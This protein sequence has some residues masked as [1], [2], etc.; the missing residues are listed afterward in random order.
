MGE[1]YFINRNLDNRHRLI[2]KLEKLT[3]KESKGYYKRFNMPEDKQ[4][5]D[6][7]DQEQ[8][9]PAHKGDSPKAGAASPRQEQSRTNSK[10]ASK[11]VSIKK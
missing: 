9:S 3:E 8:P 7:E 10:E 11:R 6:Y 2:K 5:S 1:G 4:V